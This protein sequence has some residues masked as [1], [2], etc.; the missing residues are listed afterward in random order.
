[1]RVTVDLHD[2]HLEH[3][4]GHFTGAFDVSVP[5]PS[6]KGTV[7]TGTVAVDLTDEQLAKA[8][9]K[10]F[11]VSMTGAKSES[12]EIRVVVRDRTTGIAGSL[13]IPVPKHDGGTANAQ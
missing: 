10:G 8:L 3:K 1:M 7:N 4:D 2:I 5:N 9:E 12:G 13:R 11:N 6:T